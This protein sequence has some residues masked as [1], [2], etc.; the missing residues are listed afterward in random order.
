MAKDKK[1]LR[2]HGKNW[3]L[4]YRIPDRYKLLP[5]CL[6]YKNI[7]TKDLGT[8]SLREA[9]RR[10]DII[11]HRL[12]AQAGDHYEAWLTV[13][14]ASLT[15]ANPDRPDFSQSRHPLK[16]MPK[17]K[18]PNVELALRV[19]AKGS[20]II[21]DDPKP[22]KLKAVAQA[23]RE[24]VSA[25][26]GTRKTSGRSL[27]ELTKQVVKESKVQGKARK[28]IYK[29]ERGSSWFIENLV[30]NDI[31]MADIDHEQ[32]NDFIT[33][34]LER[35]VSGST[36]KG[37]LYGLR[38]IWKRAR[39]SRLVS[40]ECPFMDHMIRSDSKQYDPFTDDEVLDLYLNAKG[41]LRTLI[42]AAATTGARASELLTAEVKTPSTFNHPCWL[43]MFKKKGKT[44]QSTRVVP[45]H[46][47]LRL[48]E[49][50]RFTLKY[51]TVQ[52]QMKKLVES[53]IE[54]PLDELTGN[55]RKLSMHS[56]RATVISKLVVE[57]GINE[58]VVGGITGHL[59]GSKS[60][61]GSIRSYIHTQDLNSK[62]KIVDMI[63]W[64]AS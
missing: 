49:G 33:L 28:T 48:E 57:H 31:D 55:P 54:N 59:G 29:I 32:V 8:D 26:F 44:E 6:P 61:A 14:K 13:D 58:K 15:E 63:P 39:Q 46:H 1:Y 17:P 36:L 42:H 11:L 41:E 12:E 23:E 30:Q 37:H 25:L 45:L 22:E 52:N 24:A 35:G 53:V 18:H 50:F 9:Q 64:R 27:T 7:L 4:H 20:S 40:G 19:L 10:R 51:K 3:W 47:S 56:F 5:E 43:F 62:K 34:E 60:T 38:Q 2:L 16:I 21:G